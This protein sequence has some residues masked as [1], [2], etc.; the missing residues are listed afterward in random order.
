MWFTGIVAGGA[1]F[2][3]P[4]SFGS[5]YQPLDIMK[6]NPQGVGIQSG[7]SQGSLGPVS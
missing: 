6:T 3:L 7:L 1:N 2:G 4:P 5:L